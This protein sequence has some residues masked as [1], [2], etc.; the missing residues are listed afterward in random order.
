MIL[1]NPMT[2][3]RKEHPIDPLKPRSVIS[4]LNFTLRQISLSVE[5]LLNCK[6]SST[7]GVKILEALPNSYQEHSKNFPRPE[8][9]FFQTL[10][11]D[12]ISRRLVKSGGFTYRD[13]VGNF[14]CR[15]MAHKNVVSNPNRS[16]CCKQCRA[17]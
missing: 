16:K 2:I 7:S 12:N 15:G 9:E 3:K 5:K 11:M 17:I 14:V 13:T 10:I 1:G 4:P 8:Q 6:I